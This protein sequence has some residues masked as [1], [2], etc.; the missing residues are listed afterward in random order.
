[1]TTYWCVISICGNGDNCFLNKKE[2]NH[3][4]TWDEWLDNIRSC[5]YSI[6]K[7]QNYNV[8]F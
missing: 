3:I 2:A 7:N 5:L 1:M 8:T 4:F 6:H